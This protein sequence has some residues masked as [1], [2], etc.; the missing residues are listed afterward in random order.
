[1]MEPKISVIIPVYN[2]EKYLKQCL[3]SVLNSTLK[4]I[5]VICV[6]DG[7]TDTSLDI[8]RE[9]ENNDDRI[10]H[11]CQKNQHAGVARN[12]GLKV[13]IGEYIHFLDA[14]DWIDTN[15]YEE[16]YKIASEQ[17]ADVAVCFYRTYDEQSKETKPKRSLPKDY[18][19]NSNFKEAPGF[20]IFNEVVPWNKIYKRD[21]LRKNNIFFDNLICAN[22]RAFYFRV[23]LAA[24]KIVTIAQYWIYYRINNS[25]S[26][27]GET[28]LKNYYV[29]FKS[30]EIIWRLFENENKN[31]KKMILRGS[32]SDF[33]YFY[34]KAKG[35]KYEQDIK[36]Q[37]NAYLRGIDI[38]LLEDDIFQC[39]WYLD[40]LDVILYTELPQNVLQN[41][42]D[43]YS[44]N[45]HYRKEID[46]LNNQLGKSNFTN[47]CIKKVKGGIKCY[48]ENGLK[49]TLK[50]IKEKAIN[51]LTK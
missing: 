5:E 36:Q 4:D 41:I 8:I 30:Y 15:A 31:V 28:R 9:Y 46:I 18:I 42:K 2:A 22:D 7:S 16:W 26:L 39:T 51:H 11:F 23:I 24:K 6:D 21:F 3:D 37:L 25:Q 13:A 1:M 47:R 27:V 43:S 34:N 32:L 14:D 12:N 40:Y 35:T 10:K 45:Q 49:Y 38:S 33:F 17:K 20:F 29:H 48:K 44:K 50:R 19:A